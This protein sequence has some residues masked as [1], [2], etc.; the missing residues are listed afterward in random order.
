MSR[1]GPAGIYVA[2]NGQPVDLSEVSWYQKAACGCISGVTLAWLDRSGIVV[3]TA[4]QAMAAFHET[5]AERQKYTALGFE[6]FAGLTA[7]VRELLATDCRHD[8][9]W[10]KPKPPQPPGHSWA[11]VHALGSR[12]KLMHLVPDEGLVNQRERRYGAGDTAA[13]C[14]SKAF[15]WKDAWYVLDGK[16]ECKRCWKRA[17]Q[18][19]AAS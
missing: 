11:A 5:P 1:G 7:D 12:P 9:K 18:M 15:H 10:G 4:E 2:I 16:V 19:M 17:E 14:G 6:C 13:L 8:P 3:T